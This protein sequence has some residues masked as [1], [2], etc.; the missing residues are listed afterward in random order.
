MNDDIR[1]IFGGDGYVY[2]IGTHKKY[3]NRWRP[4]DLRKA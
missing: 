2:K 4:K 1:V 3:F